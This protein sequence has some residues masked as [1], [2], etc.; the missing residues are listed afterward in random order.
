MRNMML[1]KLLRCAKMQISTLFYHSWL[2]LRAHTKFE[3]GRGLKIIESSFESSFEL[4][5]I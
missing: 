2:Q 4:L 3:V 5:E 1:R